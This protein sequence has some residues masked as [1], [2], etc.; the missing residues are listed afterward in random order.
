MPNNN[1]YHPC[2]SPLIKNT[3]HGGLIFVLLIFN[4]NTVLKK[5][6]FLLLPE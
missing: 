3:G 5:S 1:L 6:W 4:P 2:M